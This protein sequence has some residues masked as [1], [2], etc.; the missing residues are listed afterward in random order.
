MTSYAL[1]CNTMDLTKISHNHIHNKNEESTKGLL[2][3]NLD[4]SGDKI[5]SPIRSKLASI[6]SIKIK[7]H[8]EKNLIMSYKMF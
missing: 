5:E 7:N 2:T 1:Y 4:G 6:V 3:L 8:R